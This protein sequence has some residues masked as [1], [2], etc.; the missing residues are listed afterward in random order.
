MESSFLRKFKIESWRAVQVEESL[1][2]MLRVEVK[3]GPGESGSLAR[4]VNEVEMVLRH[5]M[6]RW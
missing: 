4:P 2:N 1:S 5:E 3:G 6:V